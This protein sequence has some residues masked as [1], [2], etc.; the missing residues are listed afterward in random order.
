MRGTETCAITVISWQKAAGINVGAMRR[1][2]VLT[3][4]PFSSLYKVLS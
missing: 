4:L 1:Q 3:I 2:S